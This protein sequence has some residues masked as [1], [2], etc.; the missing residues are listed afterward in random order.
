MIGDPTLRNEAQPLDSGFAS[1]FKY[2]DCIYTETVVKVIT[3]L[4]GTLVALKS[5]TSVFDTGFA[6]P[7]GGRHSIF[8]SLR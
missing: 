1:I 4:L 2:K 6:V 5:E 7:F 3:G 8:S